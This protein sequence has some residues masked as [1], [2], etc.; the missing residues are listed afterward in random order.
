MPSVTIAKKQAAYW[1]R[2]A[3]AAR[4]AGRHRDATNYQGQADYWRRQCSL[5]S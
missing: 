2:L 5:P 4:A 1:Q 3:D